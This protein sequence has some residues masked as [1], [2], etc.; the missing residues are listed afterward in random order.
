MPTKLALSPVAGF[1]H[2]PRVC[3]SFIGTT[4]NLSTGPEI[5]LASTRHVLAGSSLHLTALFRSQRK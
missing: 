4:R 2:N 1:V 5:S 3:S